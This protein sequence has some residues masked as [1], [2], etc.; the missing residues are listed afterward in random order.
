MRPSRF[1]FLIFIIGILAV[2]GCLREYNDIYITNVDVRQ[3]GGT[4]LTVT[5]FIQNNQ[6]KDTGVL[7]I[8]V[9][10]KD[11]STNLIVAEKDA[12]IGYIKSKSQAFNSVSLTVPRPGEYEIE[13]QVFE[14][15][16]TVAQYY[17]PSVRVAAT[18]EPGQPPDIKLTDMKLVIKQFVNG[19]SSAVVDV[20]PGIYNQGG[21]SGPLIMEVTARESP[22][23][24]HTESDEL[25]IV[26]AMKRVRGHVRLVLPRNREYTFTITV[27]ETG[28][29][30]VIGNVNEKIKLDEIKYNNP[31]TYALV[32]EG[33][34]PAEAK[35][36]EPGFEG[37][38]VVTGILLVYWISRLKKKRRDNGR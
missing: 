21:D 11:P 24:A 4:G 23:K 38:P 15:D 18:P 28:R 9:K 1:L 35:P 34:P 26:R 8:R 2:S 16:R 10:I 36:K 3:E 22:Y 14:K 19:A 31:V 33:K 6:N 13:V 25:G 30:V 37:V 7:S 20:S 17:T 12:D 32:E 29:T 27:S 5:P